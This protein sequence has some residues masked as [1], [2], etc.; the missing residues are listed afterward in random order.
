MKD[1]LLPL[2]FQGLSV[3]T[4][5][6]DDDDDDWGTSLSAA[7]CLQGVSQVIKD[8]VLQ[9]VVAYAEQGFS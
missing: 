2:I 9:P 8:D 5:D 3:I 7:C 4:F 6:E 1:N